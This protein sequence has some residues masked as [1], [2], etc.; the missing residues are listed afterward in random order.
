MYFVKDQ[1]ARS[2]LEAASI[3][4]FGKKYPSSSIDGRLEDLYTDKIYCLSEEVINK[5]WYKS[6]SGPRAF[7]HINAIQVM[8]N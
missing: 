6:V 7:K 3:N 1:E 5:D 8:L 4:E 2:K